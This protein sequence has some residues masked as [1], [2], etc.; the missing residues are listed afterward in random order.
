MEKINEVLKRCL[1]YKDE[2]VW[3]TFTQETADSPPDKIG[4]Y[5]SALSNGAAMS[6]EPFGYMFWGVHSRAH[7]LNGTKFN[8]QK[9]IAEDKSEPLQHYINRNLSPSVSFKFEE[10]VIKGKRVVVLS[11]PSAQIYPTAY[12]GKRYIRTGSGIEKII[13]HPEREAALFQILNEKKAPTDNWELQ[14]SKFHL[15]PA[16]SR[17][18]S[19]SNM[20]M[21][22]PRCRK[23]VLRLIKRLCR[24]CDSQ[25]DPG[26]KTKQLRLKTSIETHKGVVLPQSDSL[27]KSGLVQLLLR[28]LTTVRPAK[29][30]F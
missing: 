5:I 12:K 24:H 14:I 30:R 7:K 22:M 8:F 28:Q 3:F 15:R 2:T 19:M 21:E 29:E 27:S 18:D 13:R 16:L 26:L 9:D 17:R 20:S 4:E 6:G 1:S 11:I 25:A 23:T 10:D